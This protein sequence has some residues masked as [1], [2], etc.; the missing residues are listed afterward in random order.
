MKVQPNMNLSAFFDDRLPY[1]EVTGDDIIDLT[2]EDGV[3]SV[4]T[5]LPMIG[6]RPLDVPGVT[7]EDRL[8]PSPILVSAMYEAALRLRR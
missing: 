3:A 8:P 5:P 4:P 7:L 6:Y 2:I 1:D